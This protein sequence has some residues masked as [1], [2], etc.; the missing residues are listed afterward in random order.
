MAYKG[1]RP[2]LFNRIQNRIIAG[3][4]PSQRFTAKDLGEFF[5][6]PAWQT[7]ECIVRLVALGWCQPLHGP[8]KGDAFKKHRPQKKNPEKAEYEILREH[9]TPPN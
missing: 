1:F 6:E 3:T 8:D 9:W 7:L 5:G 2:D 4:F